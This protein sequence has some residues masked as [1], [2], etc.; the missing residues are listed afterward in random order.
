VLFCCW[1]QIFCFLCRWIHII[2][3]VFCAVGFILFALCFVLLD[4]HYLRCFVLLD[5]DVL[6]RFF[7]AI[8]DKIEDDWLNGH[9][10]TYATHLSNTQ[11]WEPGLISSLIIA[12]TSCL[13]GSYICRV[14]SGRSAN[15]TSRPR[16]AKAH[17]HC[18]PPRASHDIVGE[19]T[20]ASTCGRFASRLR[21]VTCL[22]PASAMQAAS[23]C[24]LLWC[25][26]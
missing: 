16:K 6:V 4:S 7:P 12:A 21:C 17:F 9:P 2:C 5:S 1:I 23:L 25:S 13:T 22:A 18:L 10:C 19:R 3:V 11:S 26:A 15:L 24:V 14:G 20:T 8:M